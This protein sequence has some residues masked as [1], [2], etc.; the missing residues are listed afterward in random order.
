LAPDRVQILDKLG[1]DI[2]VLSRGDLGNII[3][4]PLET[5]FFLSRLLFDGTLDHFPG[6]KICAAHA[7]G[8][9]PLYLGRSATSR[10]RNGRPPDC[11]SDGYPYN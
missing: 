5:T 1:I 2:Q 4:S 3:G 7:G 8:Y 9:L 11:V 10:Q 6:L